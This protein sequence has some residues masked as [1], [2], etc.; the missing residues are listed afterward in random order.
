MANGDYSEKFIQAK[1]WDFYYQKY[2]YMFTNIKYF[3]LE[4]ENDF[5]AVTESGMTYEFEIKTRKFDF[6]DDFKKHKK[7]EKLKKAYAS[8]NKSEDYNVPN[9]FFYACPPG[10][11]DKKDVPQ[12]AGLIEVNEFKVRIVK[13]APILHKVKYNPAQFF[14]RLYIRLREFLDRGFSDTLRSG[15]IKRKTKSAYKNKRK[16]KPVFP[17]QPKSLGICEEE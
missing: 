7:H 14:D 6:S 3:S 10:I 13:S 5:I 17:E 16:G 9:K 12:Y 15:D 8:K 1:L 4:N 11:I 2:K